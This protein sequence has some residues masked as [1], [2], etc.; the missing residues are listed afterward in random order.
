MD[1]DTVEGVK[2]EA[3]SFEN[4]F[5]AYNPDVVTDDPIAFDG[6]CDNFQSMPESFDINDIKNKDIAKVKTTQ[7]K[8]AN[9]KKN[10]TLESNVHRLLSDNEGKHTKRETK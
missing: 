9:T 3:E 7:R 2:E 10:K 4:N 8:R 6:V 5:Y 1:K